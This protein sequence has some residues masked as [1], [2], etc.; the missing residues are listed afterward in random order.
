MPYTVSLVNA[1]PGY[2]H[3]QYFNQLTWTDS[4]D[5]N[6]ASVNVYRSTVSGGPYTL[7]QTG[8]AMGVQLYNDFGV[9]PQTTYY[10]VTT[11]VNNVGAESSFSVEKSGRTG[12]L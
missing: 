9:A 1:H 2:S 3:R 4:T 12:P 6:A 7:I 8:I 5:P 10:Y 11:E